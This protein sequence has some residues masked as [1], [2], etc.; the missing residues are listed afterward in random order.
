M[1]SNARST[2]WYDTLSN[3]RGK[4]LEEFIINKQ[5]YIMNEVSTSTTFTNR[6]GNS[7]IDL[8]LI[9][10]QLLRR[11]SGWDISDKESNSDHSITKY[12]IGPDKKLKHKAKTHEGRFIVN[13]ENLAK[14]SRK[15]LQDS[16][17]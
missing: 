15:H 11:V 9:N 4:I 5:L 8:T 13:E 10:S 2:L 7:N 3:N 6:I 16:G 17:D 1:D 14:I 12:V